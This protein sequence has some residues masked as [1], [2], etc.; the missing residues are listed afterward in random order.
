MV[1]TAT[2]RASRDQAL[3]GFDL[4]IQFQLAVDAVHP[5]V[6]PAV[7]LDVTQMQKAQAE[8][9]VAL[10]VGQTHEPVGNDSV[11]NLLPRLVAIAGLANGKGRARQANADSLMPCRS[12]GHL[13]A[14]RW[15]PH[16]LQEPP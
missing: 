4:Q 15:A 14:M 8:T 5:L 2:P 13:T 7:A 10:V 16:F 12:C 11:V 1:D 3:L 6:V 9:P